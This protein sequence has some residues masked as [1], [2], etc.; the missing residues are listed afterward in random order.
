MKHIRVVDKMVHNGVTI[1]IYSSGDFTID[2]DCCSVDVDNIEESY[3]ITDIIEEFTFKNEV[4][5]V[6][7]ERIRHILESRIG[8]ELGMRSSEPD[9]QTQIFNSSE[10]P[11][12]YKQM[13]N[14]CEHCDAPSIIANW[15]LN[16][17][18][19]YVCPNCL[20]GDTLD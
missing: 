13:I 11:L 5:L 16:G 3:A 6:H 17:E 4:L 12:F 18:A 1:T 14:N 9:N 8:D 7:L 19:I 15:D 10:H 20:N 2:T